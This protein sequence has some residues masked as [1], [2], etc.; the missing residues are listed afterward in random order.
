MVNLYAA[1][2]D[3]LAAEDSGFE[4]FEDP[5]ENQAPEMPFHRSVLYGHP[6]TIT[7][8]PDGDNP[9]EYKEKDDKSDSR[10]I[11]VID[12]SDSY[13]PDTYLRENYADTL[14][15]LLLARQTREKVRKVAQNPP[16]K[17]SGPDKVHIDRVLKAID[18]DPLAGENPDNFIGIADILL[19]HKQY[20]EARALL[21]FDNPEHPYIPKWPN[22]IPTVLTL[23]EIAEKKGDFEAMVALL[24]DKK[25]KVR[26]P[27]HHRTLALLTH[28]LNRTQQFER[29]IAIVKKIEEAEDTKETPFQDHLLL[30]NYI[31][32]L[33]NTG[34]PRAAVEEFTTPEGLCLPSTPTP[35]ILT[36]LGLALNACREYRRTYYFMR[37]FLQ[38]S[39]FRNN[40]RFLSVITDAANRLG[41][42]RETIDLLSE[43]K[44]EYGLHR[45]INCLRSLGY[46]YV[47][48]GRLRDARQLVNFV[49]TRT[50]FDMSLIDGV[51][52]ALENAER[53]P[54]ERRILDVRQRFSPQVQPPIFIKDS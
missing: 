50:Q 15:F 22:H 25:G 8:N 45:D 40:S 3:S 13:N 52:A 30:Q 16:C 27:A 19:Q 54:D 6:F 48:T 42:Y 9:D 46:A 21:A 35:G 23:V 34:N 17:I 47:F 10:N 41:L 20:D 33:N 26:F 29:T 18:A 39:A 49:R 1:K 28:G 51:V 31:S 11:T 53:T 36:N 38:H 5:E 32:A 7:D 12:D 4:E 43:G 2:L 44:G 14:F 37:S 24:T